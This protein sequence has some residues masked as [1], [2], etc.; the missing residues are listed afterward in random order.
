MEQPHFNH[1]IQR[2]PIKTMKAV[3]DD[4][5]ITAIM[6]PPVPSFLFLDTSTPKGFIGIASLSSPGYGRSSILAALEC[7]DGGEGGRPVNKAVKVN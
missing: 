4:K 3:I 5:T 1:K 2:I 7:T 6:L